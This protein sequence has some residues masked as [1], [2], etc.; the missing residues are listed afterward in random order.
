MEVN[1]KSLLIT[2]ADDTK[3]HGMVNNEEDRAVKQSNLD[4]LEKK[5]FQIPWMHAA[6]HG[7]DVEKDAPLFRNWA[8]HTGKFQPGVDKPDPKTWKANFRCAMNSLPDIEEVKDKSIKKGNNA[9]RVYRMLPLSERPSKKGKKPKTEKDD[10]SKQIKQEPVE[11]S[12]A[13]TN[14]INEVSSDYLLS[15]TIKSEVDSTVNIVVVGQHHFDG[16]TEE[17]VIVANPPDVC[18]V[19]EVTTEC[20]EQPLSM[21]QLYPLQISPVSS[22]AE[23]E[24]TDSIPS[25]EENTEGRLHWQK[26]SIEGKQYLSNLGMRSTSHMLPSMAT[27]VTSNK[28]DLQVTIKEESCPLPYNSSWPPFPDIPLPQVVSSASASSSRPDHETRA[29]VIKKTSDI[30]QSRVKSC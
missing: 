1:V 8:I 18:Q 27:F 23:S 10:K 9:F 22:Y 6:R 15:S 17:Q 16:S 30:T 2:F 24:T 4:R 26:K 21:S 11:S 25:D 12:F 29:S 20:D 14:G 13:V 3:I 7:W 28:P 19:V 5:I